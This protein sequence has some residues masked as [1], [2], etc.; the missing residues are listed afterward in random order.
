MS[1]GSDMQVVT[2]TTDFGN[3][4]Y[5]VAELKG[6][7]LTKAGKVEIVDVSHSVPSYDIVQ[8]AFFVENIF[9]KFPIG[10]IH[11]IAV[12]HYY[13]RKNRLLVFKREGHFF[14]APD[15][16]VA[17]LLFEDLKIGEIYTIDETELK[18][19][20][21]ID[22]YAH[23]VGYIKHNLPIEDIGLKVDRINKK[24][25]LEAVVTDNQIRATIM[26]VDH[27]DNVIINLKKEK[28]ESIRNGRKFELYYKQ[29]E[30]IDHISRTYSDVTVGE[31]LCM[32][33]SDGYLEI[34]INMGKASS[35]L[36]LLRNE[37]I[38]IN[39]Y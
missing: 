22:I 30:P 7:L 9:R 15:N 28:F 3:K 6:A 33:N 36:N 12:H 34:A 39:F 1:E 5:Y 2:I 14:V 38:Q 31:V 18:F 35:M 11:I 13:A 19:E 23:V 32:F 8:A 16:G 20:T 17:S 4:D 37:T 21:M 27:Y 29:N 25:Q 24:L 26:H 10:T